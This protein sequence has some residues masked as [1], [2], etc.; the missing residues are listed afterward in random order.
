MGYYTAPLPDL[1]ARQRA[2]ATAEPFGGAAAA[3]AGDAPF[4]TSFRPAEEVPAEE[5]AAEEYPPVEAEA[6]TE[7]VAA[8]AVD[9]ADEQVEEQVE[10]SDLAAE[11]LPAEELSAS[12]N[13]ASETLD[14]VPEPEGTE[15]IDEQWAEEEPVQTPPPAPVQA[16]RS[17]ARRES[18]S[19]TCGGPRSHAL[20][21]RRC[22][23]RRR[24]RARSGATIT[25][26]RKGPPSRLRRPGCDRKLSRHTK[27]IT[28]A[29]AA[30][31]RR[32]DPAQAAA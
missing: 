2:A 32:G 7:E 22:R 19:R 25:P 1:S 16:A 13:G 29:G 11:D 12:D 26:P 9:L 23:P 6:Y 28:P 27:L 21:S 31:Y 24:P 3:A 14:Q 17:C 30:R 8:T 20:S 15:A 10:E 4:G 5:A 18:R